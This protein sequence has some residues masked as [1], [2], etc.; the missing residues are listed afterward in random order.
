MIKT[1]LSKNKV[2]VIGYNPETN[3]D[4][5]IYEVHAGGNIIYYIKEQLGQGK[6]GRTYFAE[7][8]D[9]KSTWIIKVQSRYG[10]LFY[11]RTEAIRSIYNRVN[12]DKEFK[13]L[14]SFPEQIPTVAPKYEVIGYP[15][16][17]PYIKY[18]TV[19]RKSE[20]IEALIEIARLN[21]KL[22]EHNIA[23]W[24]FGFVG[25]VNLKGSNFCSGLNYMIHPETNK[26][27]WIDYGGN[28]FC[29][30]DGNTVLAEWRNYEKDYIET[31]KR[32]MLGVL[33]NTMLKW[34]FLLHI[35][36]HRLQE[37]D[38]HSKNFIEGI[39]SMLQISNKFTKMFEETDESL[40]ESDI[41]KQLIRDT[42]QLDW[43]EPD[44]WKV[45]QE[46]LK[47]MK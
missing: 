6:D 2:F 9:D 7:R 27:R 36:Y 29:I 14:I 42:E 26:T 23:I 43:T 12:L 46:T 22:L 20:W 8:S 40:F 38:K 25:L 44:T 13:D 39:A 1:R 28:A 5:K 34:Y 17:K 15:C 10:R 31:Y 47:G 4:D 19:S 16:K 41:C 32:P 30:P 3:K 11:H 24:D 21:S 33:N 37:D 45:V 18:D 35:E